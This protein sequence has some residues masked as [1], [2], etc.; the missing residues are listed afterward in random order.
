MFDIDIEAAI[1]PV[2][3][4][5]RSKVSLP[6]LLWQRILWQQKYSVAVI[7]TWA[8][9][10]AFKEQLRQ[11]WHAPLGQGI[12]QGT[13]TITKLTNNIFMKSQHSES[14]NERRPE[15]PR[16]HHQGGSYTD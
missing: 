11:L 1:M 10:L 5:G 9:F 15:Q 6:R 7:G 16:Q 12:V 14:W 3:Q 4:T 13:P 2:S 8:D